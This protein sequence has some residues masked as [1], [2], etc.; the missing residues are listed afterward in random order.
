MVPKQ[1]L[2]KMMQCRDEVNASTTG[3]TR[4]ARRETFRKQRERERE[5]YK[6]YLN[7]MQI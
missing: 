3:E 2:K 5:R 1:G 7:V 6:T 4:R